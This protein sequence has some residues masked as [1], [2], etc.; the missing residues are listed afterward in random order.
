MR[1]IGER[2]V[3]IGGSMGGLAAARVLSEA[4]ERVTVLDRDRLP[5]E[6]VARRGVPQG[7]HAHAAI[8]GG[9]AA[10]E[11]LFPGLTEEAE[12]LGAPV[13]DAQARVRWYQRGARLTP[14]TGDLRG[15]HLS[16]PLLE[17]RV[18]ARVRAMPNVEVVEGADVLG[19]VTAPDGAVAGVRLIRG[20]DGSAEERIA[21]DLVVDSSGRGSRTPRWLEAMGRPAP[22]EESVRVD[23]T[24]VTRTFRARRAAVGG[25]LAIVVGATPATPRLGVL[26]EVEDG[27]WTVSLAGYLGERAPLDLEGF[28]AYAARLS[29]PDIADA[30]RGA[31]PLD[32]GATH[33]F[34][35]SVRRRYERLRDLPAGLLVVGDA[36]CSF[37]PIYAQ[38]MTVAAR[39]ALALR[40]CLAAGPDRLA[41][42][43]FRAAAR[44]IDAAWRVV[45]SSD[46]A[47]PAVEGARPLPVRVM[48]AYMGRLLEMAASDGR[49]SDAFLR[50]AYMVDP[51]ERVLR[52]GVALR[53]LAGRGRSAARMAASDPGAM[54]LNFGRSASRPTNSAADPVSR[55]TRW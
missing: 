34:P 40:R 47:I 23:V 43:F 8:P 2:A 7:R 19:A 26:I 27:R 46:L 22:A 30:L 1:R 10:L 6:A 12:A 54:P 41:R 4:Y 18:R 37:N 13:G 48:N 11:E 38:G 20:R 21:A 24:Y 5:S 52:P 49:L 35:A 29:N 16:R 32:D 3:V 15:L 28:I 39:Q 9:R 33:R 42:R 31:E 36:L 55:F 44:E 14:V 50:V 17:D 51:P 25:D 45:T 53:V